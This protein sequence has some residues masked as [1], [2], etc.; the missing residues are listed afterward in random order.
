MGAYLW[1]KIV[2][3]MPGLSEPRRNALT[4]QGAHYFFRIVFLLCPFIKVKGT[5]KI[6]WDKLSDGAARGIFLCINHTSFLDGLV[7]AAYCPPSVIG[8]CR[9]L[10]KASLFKLPM[11]GA[12]CKMAGHFPVYFNSSKTGNFSVDKEA[13][14]AVTERI[15]EHISTGGH[16][17]MY[18]EGQVN[19][20]PRTLQLFRRGSFATAK[21][22]QLGIWALL[23]K[24]CE[25]V[26][27]KPEAIGGFPGTVS[28]D[29]FQLF[30]EE[31]VQSLDVPTM[32]EQAQERMQARLDA[33]Y[34]DE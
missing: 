14:A 16:L 19:G 25:V 24:G 10:A 4:C 15:T 18:P 21:Q 7:F 11:F 23:T 26:W 34:K 6:M 20:T 30:T 17:T 22:H 29:M 8:Y 3:L 28:F 27:P 12:M 5:E 2:H 1:G 13:Q 9:T 33:M 32:T 31:E